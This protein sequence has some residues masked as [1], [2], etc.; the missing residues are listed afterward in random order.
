MKKT[1]LI[2]VMLTTSSFIMAQDET[3]KNL[4]AEAGKTITKAPNDTISKVW[5]TC[6]PAMGRSATQPLV[7]CRLY[8]KE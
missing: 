4:Q 5:K 1:M 8:Y 3:V 7:R 2:A 6:T